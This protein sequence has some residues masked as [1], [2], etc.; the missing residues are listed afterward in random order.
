V[1]IPL[2]FSD[3]EADEVEGEVVAEAEAG[4]VDAEGST[5]L[6]TVA[7]EAEGSTSEAEAEGET[8]ALG[9][10]MLLIPVLLYAQGG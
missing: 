4:S 9:S 8:L 10:V 1:A 6:D 5:E 7:D 3:P 2:S